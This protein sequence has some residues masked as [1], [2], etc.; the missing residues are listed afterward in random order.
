MTQLLQ[1]IFKLED[2]EKFEE[3]FEAY[4]ELYN[5]NKI[6]YEVWK[7]FYFFLW[8]AIE[9]APSSFHDKINLRDLLQIMFD[10]GKK[11]FADNADFNFIAGYT[12]SVFPYEY[13]NYD[14][15]EKEGKQ[16]L[17]KAEQLQPENLIYRL[18]YL[19]SISNV[20]PQQYRQAEIDAAP[21]VL[22]TFNGTGALNKYFRQVL[23][24][25]DKQAYR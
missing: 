4:S 11:T 6:D 1:D 9:D 5:Q 8:T 23:Y 16:M 14:D 13:G 24:R 7:H 10:E 12:V 21:K 2:D 3:A 15:L 22:E 20:D 25:L 17:L 19:G 18:V